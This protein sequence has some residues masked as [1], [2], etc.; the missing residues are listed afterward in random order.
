MFTGLNSLT[1]LVINGF[2]QLTRIISLPE[3]LE[4]VNLSNNAIG[5][6]E[7]DAFRLLNKLKNLNLYMNNLTAE[8]A[9]PAFAH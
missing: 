7:P 6:I 2:K 9:I 3:T 1:T 5:V 4:F 8:K